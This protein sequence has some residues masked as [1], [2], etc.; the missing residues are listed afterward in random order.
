MCVL[1]KIVN[2]EADLVVVLHTEDVLASTKETKATEES[3]LH[4]RTRAFLGQGLEKCDVR[5]GM[6]RHAQQGGEAVPGR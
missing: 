4:L 5:L 6:L 1:K 3:I 2:D